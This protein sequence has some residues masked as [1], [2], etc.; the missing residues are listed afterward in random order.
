MSP[1]ATSPI[2]S[3]LRDVRGEEGE[4]L[5]LAR[6]AAAIKVRSQQSGIKADPASSSVGTA[7]RQ[8]IDEL[9]KES[10][11]FLQRA[12]LEVE[13][14]RRR[15]TAVPAAAVEATKS[16]S[17]PEE[18]TEPAPMAGPPKSEVPSEV[19][20]KLYRALAAGAQHTAGAASA[21]AE[22]AAKLG[23]QAETASTERGEE[24]RRQT[25][26]LARKAAA[27]S[28]AS[29]W[30]KA[31]AVDP[32]QALPALRREIEMRVTQILQARDALRTLDELLPGSMPDD[33]GEKPRTTA[34]GVQDAQKG[35]RATAPRRALPRAR[36]SKAKGPMA[37]PGGGTKR[38]RA[39]PQAG[40]RRRGA[41][42]AAKP[43]ETP[44]GRSSPE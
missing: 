30:V 8:R 31:R 20:G 32:A 25:S 24:L 40:R 2:L 26:E 42:A 14:L 33:A 6:L 36:K 21:A 18:A 34:G 44:G 10:E 35:Q 11:R 19:A 28:V 22:Q 4:L 41:A 3:F 17:A 15:L 43:E 13:L 1:E 16:A 27:M 7:V 9:A 23:S 12:L 29:L 39:H 37:Q 38:V 5:L